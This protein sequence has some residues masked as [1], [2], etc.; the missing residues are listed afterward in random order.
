MKKI[1][2]VII[3][4]IMILAGIA[5]IL[6]FDTIYSISAIIM[7]TAGIYYWFRYTIPELFNSNEEKFIDD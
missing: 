7:G 6:G 5:W 1:T 4:M 3:F 2:E